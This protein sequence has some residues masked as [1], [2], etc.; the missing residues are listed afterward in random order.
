MNNQSKLVF[1]TERILVRTLTA[2]DF[3]D[4]YALQT[5]PTV[6]KHMAGIR[7]QQQSQDEFNKILHHQQ[8][9]GFSMWLNI[10]KATGEII[11]I[12]GLVHNDLE[13]GRR[14]VATAG[15][16]FPKFWNQ[17]YASEIAKA[18]INWAFNNLDINTI[19]SVTAINNQHARRILERIGM[20]YVKD[21]QH[22]N[23]L[24]AYYEIQPHTSQTSK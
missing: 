22:K 23:E 5:D 8:E 10:L 3:A 12:V 15:A 13:D 14:I 9:Y 18:S 7:T 4:F 1:E 16:L 6:M 20:H 2:E 17:G 21:I 19:G 24:S 11:G